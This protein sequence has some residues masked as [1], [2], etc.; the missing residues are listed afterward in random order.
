MVSIIIASGIAYS[1]VIVYTDYS[2]TMY[3]LVMFSFGFFVGSLHHIICITCT[4]DI[5]RQQKYQ[6]NKRAT[7]TITGII[8]GIGSSGSGLGQAFLGSMIENFGWQY[9]YMLVIA[10][11]TNLTIFPMGKIFYREIGE[12]NQI[13]KQK[14]EFQHQE[15]KEETDTLE[16]SGTKEDLNIN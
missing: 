11:M 3:T 16:I 4:A 2:D 14:K 1:I 5:G 10:V 7:S 8:D 12:I 13:R 15:L 9:G 6:N